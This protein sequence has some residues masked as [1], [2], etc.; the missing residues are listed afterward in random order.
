MASRGPGPRLRG[1]Q[2][3][4][5]RL[6][7]LVATVQGGRSSVLILRGEP[8]IGK[9]AL[10]E[11]TRDSATGCRL[12]R[13][14]GVE[15]EMELAFGGLH[16][17][18]APF[19]DHLPHLPEPQREALSTAFGLSAGTPPDRFLVGLA[20]LSLLADVAEKE[21]LIC[22]VDDAQW[23]DTVSA[24]TIA[25]VVRRLL[26]E[27]IGLVIAV[28]DHHLETELAGLPQLDLGRLGDGDARALL[29]SATPG[30]LDEQVRD[31]IVAEAQGNPLALLELPR[32]LTPAELAGGFGRPDARPLASQIEQSFLRRVQSLP[33]RTQRLLLVAAAE[34]VG[35][36]TLLAR[37]AGLLGI[38]PAAAGPAEA[39]GLITIGTRVRFRHPLV[40]SAAYRVAAPQ[41]RQAVH[42]A[43]ADA[44]DAR[45]DPDRR[46][47][48]L[49]NA[50]PGP[51]ETVAAELVRSA[52]RA[53]ARG[54]VAAAAAF[55]ERAAELTPDAALRGARALAAARDKYQA[56]G[57]DAAL[58]LLDAAEL[59]PLDE[60]R[61]AE[62]SLLRGRITF[63][64]TSAGAA[65]P[66][67]LKAGR[68]LEPLDP[69]LAR[70]TYRD[71]LYAAL[72]AG[73]LANGAQVADVARAALAA[74]PGPPPERND[75][76]LN[77]TATAA[78]EGYTA[79][80]PM[81]LR[82]L[83][84]FR[85]DGVSRQE[86]LGWL[87][88]ACRMA[89]N[90][91]DFDSY[92]ALSARLVDLARETG[93]LSV[94]PSALLLHLSAQVL[95]GELDAAGAL[96]AEAMTIGEVTGSRFMA[97]YGALVLEPW[98]GSEAATLQ[99]IETIT[100]DTALQGEGKVAT[101]T[102]WARAV[103]YNA[104]GRY[105]EAFAA[106]ERGA[107]HPRELGLSTWS[108]IELVE[109]AAR[110]GRRARA[111]EAARRLD[112]M[113]G[114]SGT[115]WAL[116]TAASA[117]AQVSDGQAADARYREAIE[118]LG[119][120]GVRMTLART[121]LLYGEWLRRENRRVDAREQLGLAHE[122]LGRMGAEAF[123]ERARRE[124]Q[125]TG[126]TVRRRPVEARATLTAHEAQV[127][128]LAADGL[129]NSEIGAQ[130]YISPHT[131]E[132]HLRKIFVK[133][134][135]ASRRQLR[136]ALPGGAAA[137][138]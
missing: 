17:L 24:Q 72:T 86:G 112:E 65:L 10:L 64:S 70:E 6:D 59:S 84:A 19:L 50:T 91:W 12:T 29:D 90:V 27:R 15:S 110:S 102:Q 57:Y 71:A 87:P 96:V 13:A 60:H 116:G 100:R 128:R 38:E 41:E 20:V 119:R 75:L 55:L 5:E 118:R 14:A 49:A 67:L 2:A 54:G 39:A 62:A 8:G 4:C 3:E 47:W 89:H 109:A 111:A 11:H 68:H 135:I 77:G 114:A 21:P 76:L 53:Q 36:V 9:S 98:R 106:A 95:A 85:T 108:T 7:R 46:A 127:A 45:A 33:P 48:H 35:D 74:P 93:A 113:A 137:T 124:L 26:A 16:Q 101:A 138:A 97:Q 37:A 69:A 63:A 88:L 121:H 31:R 42:R 61:L 126:E 78:I 28:R 99:V 82:A 134:G 131:V 120:T 73:R 132:W 130:L 25:F 51:D 104:H 52:G 1:R 107:E 56:G 129:T 79:G 103:L 40:R 115:D 18:C 23:L 105:E 133:L 30:R 94:L 34:P 81:V 58:E 32:G 80:T 43:L 66:L 22:L 117:R 83:D 123:A 44:T 92:A 125:A 136:E 122:L